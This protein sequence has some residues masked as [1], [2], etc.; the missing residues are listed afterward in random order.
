MTFRNFTRAEE[1][2]LEAQRC[3]GCKQECMSACPVGINI[4]KVMEL[5]KDGYFD[6]AGKLVTEQNPFASACGRFCH[7]PCQKQCP[8]SI[9]IKAIER[10]LGDTYKA[11]LEKGKKNKKTIAIVGSGIAGL[12][13]AEALVK[14]GY[15]V[16]VYDA[17]ARAGG[18]H[19]HIVSEQG[20]PSKIRAKGVQR[21]LEHVQFHPNSIIGAMPRLER[22][23]KDNDAVILATGAN[24][25]MQ[26]HIQG[27]DL[28]NI[29]TP[30]EY[31]RGAYSGGKA[32]TV[33]IGGGPVALDLARTA[34]KKGDTVTVVDRR[35]IQDLPT[36][37]HILSAAQEE[38]VR[39]MLLTQPVR[40]VGDKKVSGIECTQ[41]MVTQSEFDDS[42]ITVPIEDSKF[43]IECDRVIVAIGFEPNPSMGNR[44]PMLRTVGKNRIWV[45]E[46]H[47]T[48]IPRVFAAGEVVLGSSSPSLT[49]AHARKVAESVD[50]FVQNP[51]KVDLKEEKE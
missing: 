41:M 42:W 33:V 29:I 51:P 1:V 35:T 9:N 8:K 49:I 45:D 37:P 11:D 12:T 20:F 16:S 32:R 21:V 22:I 18:A 7:A 6:E 50:A 19:E 48:T 31:I 3:G 39:F 28:L 25:P 10:F 38:G 14:K 15:E 44:Y 27:E 26:L 30:S 23:H 13:C 2:R 43:V 5:L 24:N 36:D 17:H 46:R 47:M 34:T 4:P 40:F